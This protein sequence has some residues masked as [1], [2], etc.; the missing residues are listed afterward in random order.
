[1]DQPGDLGEVAAG[2]FDGL[3]VGCRPGQPRDGE[4]LEVGG[5]T[6][7]HVVQAHWNGIDGLRQCQ[8]MAVLAFL[9]RL[10]VVGVGGEE[11]AST[12]RIWLSSEA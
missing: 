11:S 4:R 5:G 2:F 7:R 3:D 12:P 9:T 10:V 8:E 1:M 6:A